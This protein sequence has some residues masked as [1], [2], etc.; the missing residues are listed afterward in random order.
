MIAAAERGLR[1]HRVTHGMLAPM[2]EA[3]RRNMGSP[4]L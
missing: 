2:L 4:Q 1:Q 3:R